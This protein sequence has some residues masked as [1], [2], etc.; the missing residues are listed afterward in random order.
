MRV[1]A[2]FIAIALM[3]SVAAQDASP[4]PRPRP[5]S[6]P[7]VAAPAVSVPAVPL[8]RKRPDADPAP[9]V[10]TAVPAASS[11]ATLAPS[12]GGT[13]APAVSQP[14]R[15]YRAACPAQ[16]L[17][18]VQAE[19]LPPIS[20]G[21]CSARSPLSVTAVLANGRMVPFSGA[22]ILD[23]PMATALPA[24]VAG[25]DS[26]LRAHDRT[27]I[28]SVIVG[29]SYMCR[30]VNNAAGGNLSFHGLA[31]AIDV[32]G[33]RLEDGRTVTVE[34][35]WPGTEEQGSRIVRFAH[36][37]A[38]THFTTVLGPEANALHRDHLHLDLGCHGKA[39]TARLCE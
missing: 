7:L 29:T 5:D 34:T 28:D 26:Y 3:P 2:A 30:A 18:Q 37:A 39:C 19:M 21:Q 17:G 1:L 24:W 38:C 22:A 13:A 35:A 23:C 20:D 32:V 25:V 27:G 14:E 4:L 11:P 12:P 16:L 9:A 6:R 36:D 33:F 8:P 10:E 15:I 31:D